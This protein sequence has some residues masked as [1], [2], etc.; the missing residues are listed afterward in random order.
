[1]AE[2][3]PEAEEELG[4]WL[5]SLVRCLHIGW[6]G[7]SNIT[8]GVF[9]LNHRA[10]LLLEHLRTRGASVPMA[11]TPLGQPP[12]MRGGGP[13]RLASVLARGAP[14]YMGRDLG[15]MPTRM[16]GRA[17]LRGRRTA[18]QSPALS[19]GCISTARPTTTPHC[20]L[21][22]LRSERGYNSVGGSRGHAVWPRIAAHS[23]QDCLRRSPLRPGPHGQNRYCR[24][25]LSSLASRRGYTE[26]GC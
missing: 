11:S 19:V 20:G 15:L 8:Q 16:L 3:L 6:R 10:T 4:N 17:P 2:Q 5:C 9:H 24:W 13:A 22:L 26:T 7:S 21:L 14:V 23:Y 12:A 25:V 1:M 18:G